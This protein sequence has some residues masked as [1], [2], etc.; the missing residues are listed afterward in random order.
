MKSS[1]FEKAEEC[2]TKLIHRNP[3][4]REYFFQLADCVGA[5]CDDNRLIEFYQVMQK[6]FPRAKVIFL[7]FFLRVEVV[8]FIV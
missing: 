7:T 4:K 1:N 5:T 6:T 8:F 2:L 3:E